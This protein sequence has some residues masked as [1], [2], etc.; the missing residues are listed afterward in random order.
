LIH[1]IEELEVVNLTL[2][3]YKGFTYLKARS[4][5]ISLHVENFVHYGFCEG[6]EDIISHKIIFYSPL[7]VISVDG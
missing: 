7:A 5:E 6:F 1:V 2:L 4:D 3:S